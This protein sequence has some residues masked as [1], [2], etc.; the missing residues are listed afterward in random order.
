MDIGGEELTDYFSKM[1]GTRSQVDFATAHGRTLASYIKEY[2]CHVALDPE[3]PGKENYAYEV[4]GSDIRIQ[5]SKHP[6]SI[7]TTSRIGETINAILI[8]RND[9]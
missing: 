1:L 9:L 3:R 8:P 4:D 2:A 6:A 5:I 7:S